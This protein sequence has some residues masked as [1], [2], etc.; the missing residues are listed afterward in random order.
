[1]FKQAA[2]VWVIFVG[3]IYLIENE[4]FGVGKYS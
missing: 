2:N 4:L 3:F 1:M